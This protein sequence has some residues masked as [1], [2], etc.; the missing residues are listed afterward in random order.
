MIA[1]KFTRGQLRNREKYLQIQSELV[2][3]WTYAN[4]LPELVDQLVEL[5]PKLEPEWLAT[6]RTCT[7]PPPPVDIG[8][9]APAMAPLTKMTV[10]LNPRPGTAASDAN[11]IGGL[12]LWPKDEPWP[13]CD[14]H[15]SAFI[16]A[17]QVRKEDYPEVEFQ[18]GTDL[19]QVL[20]CPNDHESGCCPTVRVV[21]RERAGVIHAGDAHPEPTLVRPEAEYLP[22]PCLLYPERIVEY[23]NH[24]EDFSTG[25]EIYLGDLPGVAAALELNERHKVG[26]WPTCSEF[27]YLYQCALSTC[28][29]TK[30]GGYPDWIQ[31][32]DYPRCTCG[33][34][35]DH[36]VS[37]GSWEC[38]G[39]AW[40][41]WLPIEERDILRAEFNLQRSV[42]SAM[43]C[44][45]GDVGNLYVFICRKCP[46]WPTVTR[47]QF[48]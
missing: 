14:Q 33:A 19:M 13:N 31:N 30:L 5:R 42:V 27:A 18:P 15:K 4:P 41:R 43:D 11:K 29:G 44:T 48:S 26:T 38:G 35:M 12:F 9:L 21:W 1:K 20:W 46:G 8:R 22:S 37:F 7:T 2:A 10:R 24:L 36:L 39:A 34:V 32:P 45:F 3:G 23:P 25:D 16:T 17:L 40:F 28:E 47:M 6:V